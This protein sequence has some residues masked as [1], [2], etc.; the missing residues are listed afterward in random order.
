[1]STPDSSI[2]TQLVR[3]LALTNNQV[4]LQQNGRKPNNTFG[5]QQY[6]SSRPTSKKIQPL[7][8]LGE[9]V[10]SIFN[11]IN[12][13]SQITPAF[14]NSLNESLKNQTEPSLI[15][16][17]SSELRTYYNNNSLPSTINFLATTKDSD[18]NQSF[19]LNKLTSGGYFAFSSSFSTFITNGSTTYKL[20]IISSGADQ[21]KL[22]IESKNISVNNNLYTEI[23]NSPFNKGQNFSLGSNTYY[24]AGAG[25]P[26]IIFSTI[27]F[28]NI[29]VNVSDFLG[30]N[31]TVDPNNVNGDSISGEISN[32]LG[33]EKLC[34]PWN[35]SQSVTPN[36]FILHDKKRIAK[37]SI[38]IDDSTQK[39][40]PNIT[41]LYTFPDAST[42]DYANMNCSCIQKDENT[43]FWTKGTSNL[44][45]YTDDNF[46]TEQSIGDPTYIPITDGSVPPPTD[47][48]PQFGPLT[49]LIFN[50]NKTKIYVPDLYL[51]LLRIV[52]ISDMGNITV[53]TVKDL[54]RNNVNFS[55][56]IDVKEYDDNNLLLSI[57]SSKGGN[58]LILFDINFKTINRIYGN[59]EPTW[60]DSNTDNSSILGNT[61]I[62]IDDTNKRIYFTHDGS[63]V[64]M[65]DLNTGNF[66]TIAGSTLGYENN[67]Q[68]SKFNKLMGMLYDN[69][70][71]SLYLCD[72]ANYRI[73]KVKLVLKNPDPIVDCTYASGFNVP[74]G[75]TIDSSGNLYVCNVDNNTVSK[76]D[77]S[78]SVTTYASEINA[79]Y[80]ITIDS[81]GN[82]YV[83]SLYYNSIYKVDTSGTVSTYA[84]GFNVPIG[85]TIDS[86]GNLYVCNYGNK[87]VS[88]VNTSGDVTTYASGINS[89]YAITID[90][91]GN[92]YVCNSANNMVSKIN[93][94]GTVSTYAS[95]INSP[96]GITIDSS[97]N[98]Y[99]CDNNN[100][101]LKVDTSGTVSTYA[102]GFNGP[103][104]ITIDSSGNLYVCNA[105][106]NRVCKVSPPKTGGNTIVT[107]PGSNYNIQ[108]RV[109]G[110][111]P[112]NITQD[113]KNNFRNDFAALIGVDPAMLTIDLQSGSLIVNISFDASY[114]ANGFS[115]NDSA[116]IKNTIAILNQV[117]ISDIEQIKNNRNIPLTWS[118][119]AYI[120]YENI[121]INIDIG[122][123]NTINSRFN[124]YDIQNPLVGDIKN[125][126]MYTIIGSYVVRINRNGTISRIALFPESQ[127][128][129]YIFIDSTSSFLVIPSNVNDTTIANAVDNSLRYN[130][131]YVIR[132]SDGI[133]FTKTLNNN[134]FIQANAFNQFK[135]RLYFTSYMQNNALKY[136]FIDLTNP[137]TTESITSTQ[138]INFA[139]P[140][141]ITD[142][143]G[144]SNFIFTSETECYLVLFFNHIRK[145][146]I[147]VSG[148]TITSNTIIAGTFYDGN[149]TGG[150]S[151]V[152]NG[153]WVNS[154]GLV[155]GPYL[156][157]PIGT[158]AFFSFIRDITYDSENNRLLVAD[159]YAQRIRSVDL[160]AGNNYRVTTLAGTSP[161][162]YGQAINQSTGNFSQAVLDSLGQVGVWNNGTNQMPLYTKVNSSY[163]NSTFQRPSRVVIFKGKIY[164]L[165]DTGTRQ[166]VNNR[167]SDFQ[168]FA[169]NIAKITLGSLGGGPSITFTISN[170][171]FTLS[172]TEKQSF[173]NEFM[174]SYPSINKDNLVFTFTSGSIVLNIKYKDNLDINS[175]SNEELSSIQNLEVAFSDK[176]EVLANFRTAITTTTFSAGGSITLDVGGQTSTITG[177]II[178]TIP[179]NLIDYI[180]E[181]LRN[182]ISPVLLQFGN[183]GTIYTTNGLNDVLSVDRIFGFTTKICTLPP[184]IVPNTTRIFSRVLDIDSSN[185][186][187]IVMDSLTDNTT[188]IITSPN[189]FYIVDILNKTVNTIT[190]QSLNPPN[191]PNGP[192]L[193]INVDDRGVIFNKYT[194]D[195]Y[196][197]FKRE[198]QGTDM[199]SYKGSLLPNG[200]ID[201]NTTQILPK[202]FIEP[203]SASNF[204]SLGLNNPSTTFNM[205]ISA[206]KYV[207]I[208]DNMIYILDISN[209]NSTVLTKVIGEINPP[210]QK[211]NPNTN[212]EQRLWGKFN[213]DI[214]QGPILFSTI[215][216]TSYNNITD[217][218][219]VCDQFAKVMLSIS[220]ISGTGTPTI[221]KIYG[222]QNTDLD[223]EGYPNSS[224]TTNPIE[225]GRFFIN[226]ISGTNKGTLVPNTLNFICPV[227]ATQNV[228]DN[229]I[230]VSG[231]SSKLIN[232]PSSITQ[233]SQIYETTVIVGNKATIF[234][235]NNTS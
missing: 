78:R 53:E 136:E 60:V 46:D 101:V 22:R 103:I 197:T 9:R 217:T 40:V 137:F 173:I 121:K 216:L 1:M 108:F 235:I 58:Q 166:L 114:G 176:V 99:V 126:C 70:T 4:G 86:S 37:I 179:T 13:P 124:N 203:R 221:T 122:L 32:T 149:N 62:E 228:L 182:K 213:Y 125:N 156:D 26:G 227:L 204:S 19:P 192:W 189:L 199:V 162:L 84:N 118:I 150:W 106:N 131:V 2:I 135:N 209:I 8:T 91:S 180:D 188:N 214:V 93:T 29:N 154:Y 225:R 145:L 87:T 20:T 178:I 33:S 191:G 193:F 148:T 44:I 104:G 74:Y 201:L 90:S 59:G 134:L 130:K 219:F 185:K 47:N 158:N 165:D 113:M 171:N 12:N 174:K 15:P 111:T 194:N 21:G 177:E 41:T 139:S 7:F 27:P 153:S 100:T 31:N 210:L 119:D 72:G 94:S 38:T 152:Q 226:N 51:S 66:Y 23:T 195:I 123:T 141:S 186:Y 117:S 64:R 127:G 50:K 187:L 107:I 52:D 88:K 222:T 67:G 82:L 223:L 43:F 45:Y 95:G 184:P 89:P 110:I 6:N 109:I 220:P 218:L 10:T 233:T 112:G 159:V 190:I 232:N 14:F 230:Y 49:K 205:F 42:T 18:G 129:R 34:F 57:Q 196:I 116:L 83:S 229:R 234:K 79:P 73:R 198:R 69:A 155:Y 120:D 215:S 160:R 102:S 146:V 105:G 168:P 36:T 39:E 208:L 54:N 55:S 61:S 140:H 80:A 81:S 202:F 97:G 28:P 175:L 207:M 181:K 164:V 11:Q 3:S 85:I 115:D 128:C 144:V 92:L 30:T 75:I 224:L 212:R 167:V 133:V 16:I 68:L 138:T 211:F 200:T 183:D 157:A 231:Y 96:I 169:N 5:S 48:P 65:L 24:Y 161:V 142:S 172:D 76:V 170:S 163:L 63:G 71:Q 147:N 151:N 56:V 17:T 35:L 25:S 206:N 98:L 132:L 143:T 77:T